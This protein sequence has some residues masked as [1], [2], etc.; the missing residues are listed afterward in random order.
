I[1]TPRLMWGKQRAG[2]DGILLLTG[3]VPGLCC[4]SYGRRICMMSPPPL[5]SQVEALTH[6]P[7]ISG[8]SGTNV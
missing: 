8:H 6:H 7:E 2:R 4:G 1:S 5:P 3:E